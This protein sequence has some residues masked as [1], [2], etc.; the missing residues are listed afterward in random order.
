[1]RLA[2]YVCRYIGSLRP[3]ALSVEVITRL[4][5]RGPPWGSL[6]FFLLLFFMARWFPFG[7]WLTVEQQR[8]SLE[9]KKNTTK[10]GTFNQWLLRVPLCLVHLYHLAGVR[11]NR[12]RGGGEKKKRKNLESRVLPSVFLQF[13]IFSYFFFPLFLA[14][15][16]SMNFLTLSRSISGCFFAGSSRRSFLRNIIRMVGEL[17][18][19][20]RRRV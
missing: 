6:L 2:E 11:E 14:C 16:P 20:S 10:E 3:E 7:W 8:T 1:M 13:P 12:E 17:E 18:P 19:G 5:I 15:S 4:R 9:K